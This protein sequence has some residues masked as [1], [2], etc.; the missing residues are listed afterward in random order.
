MPIYE[1]TDGG[2]APVS[3]TTFA[4]EDIKERE[5]LQQLVK[6]RIAVLAGELPDVDELMV[7]SE[8]FSD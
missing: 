6:G 7:L 4:D 8:E 2:L 1:I 5:D 3:P